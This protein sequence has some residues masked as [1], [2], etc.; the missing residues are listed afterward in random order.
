MRRCLIYSAIVVTGVRK[1]AIA[2]GPAAACGRS[3]AGEC[4][5]NKR[6]GGNRDRTREPKGHRCCKP[7]QVKSPC[8]PSVPIIDHR[9]VP[10]IQLMKQTLME[11][12]TDRAACRRIDALAWA[13]CASQLACGIAAIDDQSRRSAMLAIG[14]LVIGCRLRDRFM[15]RLLHGFG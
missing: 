5:M 2:C 12:S 15:L 6:P 11:E 7:Y 1:I 13:C 8:P 4:S 14:I 3:A 10:P 9:A